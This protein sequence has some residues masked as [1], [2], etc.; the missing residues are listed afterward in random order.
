[1]SKTAYTYVPPSLAAIK[2][3]M[4]A[5]LVDK[6]PKF[7]H[8]Y[9]PKQDR[10]MF[11]TDNYMRMQTSL[12]SSTADPVATTL[13]TFRTSFPD[14]VFA[15]TTQEEALLS[16]QIR[17]TIEGLPCH[18]SLPDSPQDLAHNYKH[19]LL[20]RNNHIGLL[21]SVY[22]HISKELKDVNVTLLF[23][24]GFQLQVYFSDNYGNYIACLGLK[25]EDAYSKKGVLYAK[26]KNCSYTLHSQNEKFNSVITSAN[27][28][29]VAPSK[30]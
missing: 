18:V 21:K 23:G 29:Q 3:F 11:V 6:F 14:T 22:A 10:D 25:C 24:G 15:Y 30:A 28:P 19:A 13:A 12:G 20:I 7:L 26:H 2:A 1:M 4:G 8:S 9:V 27:I 5:G 17:F 16:P